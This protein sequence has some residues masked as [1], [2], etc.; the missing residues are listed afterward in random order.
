MRTPASG[1]RNPSIRPSASQRPRVVVVDVHPLYREAV[2]REVRQ[3]PALE[4]VGE[5]ADG[6]SALAAIVERQPE[7]AVLDIQLPEL[8]GPRV[9]NAV[10]RDRLPTRIVFLTACVDAALAYQLLG[11]GAA[12]YLSKKATGE[13]ICGALVAVARGQSVLAP[14]IQTGIAGEIRLRAHDE[15]PILSN[16][17]QD[18]IKLV[19][20]G[21]SAPE[22]GRTLHLSTATVKS[23]QLHV[24]QKIGVSD[25]AAAVAEAMRRGLI[26]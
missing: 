21:K 6:R 7:V 10:A 3:R 2:A 18:I 14:E 11:A 12:G 19:A 20:A 1:N 5:A 4:L 13:Q 17:E 16:R 24:Y 22:I 25:R 23:H 26:E 15:R 8:D 9:L